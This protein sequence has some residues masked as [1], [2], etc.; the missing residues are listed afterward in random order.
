MKKVI[1]GSIL[2]TSVHAFGMEEDSSSIQQSDINSP[3]SDSLSS[4]GKE[5]HQITKKIAHCRMN[6]GQ[7]PIEF[8][9]SSSKKTKPIKLPSSRKSEPRKGAAK[10]NVPER[11]V[12]TL[13][14]GKNTWESGAR[15]TKLKK[16]SRKKNL[17][18]SKIDDTLP[19]L[20]GDVEK[21]CISFETN[22]TSSSSETSESDDS[23]K[24]VKFLNKIET[25][26]QR[27]MRDENAPN[28]TTLKKRKRLDNDK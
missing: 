25:V 20:I 12:V 19:S 7:N 17:F 14:A 6:A 4:G 10:E 11:D 27:A 23:V 8:E 5:V 16:E 26:L 2:I 9:D 3:W 13:I 28:T 1:L 21:L 22:D 24:N 18:G 15:K